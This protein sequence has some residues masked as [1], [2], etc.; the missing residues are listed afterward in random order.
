MTARR[1]PVQAVEFVAP[2]VVEVLHRRPEYAEV[3][4]IGASIAEWVTA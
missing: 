4:P 1:G 3:F 2:A